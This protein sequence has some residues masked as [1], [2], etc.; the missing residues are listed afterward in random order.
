MPKKSKKIAS[1]QAQLQQRAK[2]KLRRGAPAP[3]PAY[4]PP[5]T[6]AEA[7]DTDDAPEQAAIAPAAA[8]AAPAAPTP[9]ATSIAAPRPQLSRRERAAEVV[10]TTASL[11]TEVMRIGIVA[12]IVAGILVGLKFGTDLGV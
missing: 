10:L 2:Q 4:V 9:T 12:F 6:P 8:Q 1:R 5:I 7:P 11:R 3:P